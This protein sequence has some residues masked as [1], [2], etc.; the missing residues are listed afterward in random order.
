[1]SAYQVPLSEVAMIFNGKTPGRADQREDGHP[2]L[3]IR[4]VDENGMF[5]GKF[6]SFVDREF[7][8]RFD[9]KCAVEGD[10]LILNAAHTA[11]YV[12]SKTFYVTADASDALVTG[13]WLIVRPKNTVLDAKYANFWLRSEAARRQIR[14]LVKGIHLYPKDVARLEISLPPLNEQKRIAAILDQLDN[15]RRLRR[16]TVDRL[17]DLEQVIFSKMFGDPGADYSDYPTAKL[18]TV[19]ELI[20]GDRSSNYPSGDDLV[21]S[22]VLFLGTKNINDGEIDLAECNFITEAK[23]RSL[24]RGKLKKH[25]LVITLRGTLGQC[26]EFNCKYDTGF[27][28]AQMMIIRPSDRIRPAFLRSFIAHPRTQARLTHDRSGSAVPQLTAKQVGELLVPIPPLPAQ[29]KFS[30]RLDAARALAKSYG[31]HLCKLNDNFQSLQYRAF[32][33][34]L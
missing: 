4:D 3:K 20:N 18:S 13:E 7:A 17:N 23:F 9:V 27:I 33:G 19:A 29:T 28:N 5:R 25:D 16:L 10:T 12:G 30:A 22:G 2:V 34:K 31:A 11:A 21:D 6:E 8:S 15:V 26:A 1:M 14:D 32:R 24:S